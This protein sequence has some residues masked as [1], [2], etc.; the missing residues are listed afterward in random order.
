MK[1]INVVKVQVKDSSKDIYLKKIGE[2][3]TKMSSTEGLI[4]FKLVEIGK[5]RYCSIGEW[6]NESA[7]GAARP[8]MVAFL[9][10]IRP[11]LDE[12][13]P[14]LGVTDPASGPLILST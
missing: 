3:F 12:M 6:E 14:E 7:I 2:F 10:T 13:S 1:F 5:N 9:N 4:S 11:M 8:K